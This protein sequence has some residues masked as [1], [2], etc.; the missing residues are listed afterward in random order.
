MLAMLR[1]KSL[2][3]IIYIHLNSRQR[4]NSKLDT[5]KSQ[6]AHRPEAILTSIARDKV[7]THSLQSP[8]QQMLHDVRDDNVCYNCPT[9]QRQNRMQN[10]KELQNYHKIVSCIRLPIFTQ[11]NLRLR[12]SAQQIHI[13][14]KCIYIC[15][16][17]KTNI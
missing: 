2:L 15:S 7:H 9:N 17:C 12:K 6:T 1:I 11:R 10:H 8:L 3:N 13:L 16:S 14:L 4:D 5:P